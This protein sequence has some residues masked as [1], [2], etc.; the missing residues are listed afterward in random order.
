MPILTSTVIECHRADLNKSAF[1]YAAMLMRPEYRSQ[2]DG[3]YAK[4]IEAIVRKAPRGIK[5]QHEDELVAKLTL[6]CPVCESPLAAMD[7]TCN[8]CKT[9]LPICIAT[10]IENKN[11]LNTF[12]F[13]F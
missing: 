10:V 5:E 1:T 9:T 8:Q 4:K 11:V 6:P 3:K 12:K 13:F 7:V 2:I